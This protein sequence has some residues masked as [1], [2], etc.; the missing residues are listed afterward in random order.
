MINLNVVKYSKFWL[1]LSGI[2]IAASIASVAIFGLN[3]GIDFTGGSLLEVAVDSRP[4]PAQVR[5]VLSGAGFEAT[6][7][8]SQE[9]HTFIRLE[10]ITPEQHSA[11]LAALVAGFGT[12][13]EQRFDSIGPIVGDT[14][15]I[16]TIEAVV[17]TLILIL[18]YVSWSFRKVSQPVSSW[19]YATLTVA[20]AFHD[21][22]I[23]IGAF[24]IL[25]RFAGFQID[26]TFVAAV[27]TILGYS[28]NDTII[29]FDRTRENLLANRHSDEPFASVVN[30]SLQQTFGRSINT[31]VTVLLSLSAV[32][33]FGGDTIRPFAL[34]LMIGI[35]A[36]TYSSI[37]IASPLLVA[38]NRK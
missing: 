21:V 26:T 10:S 33:I 7:Q 37:F 32:V 23:P 3:F 29:V 34:A 8:Q 22:I 25:G 15:R 18:L 38:W 9:G 30:R 24:A 16:R 35:V 11:V 5:E 19:K 12:V 14:L 36:G 28:I 2:L 13:T 20:T 6:V 1:T 4:E 31:S 27:L 17:L